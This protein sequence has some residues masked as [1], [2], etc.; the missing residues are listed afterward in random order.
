[1]SRRQTYEELIEEQLNEI[2]LPDE[3]QSW[4]RM[5]QLLEDDDGRDRVAPP[6]FL[7][8]CAGWGL[9]LIALLAATW[10]LVRQNK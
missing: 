9:L 2:P 6:V 8:S 4:Q 7:R 5:K 10:L 3:E 1:M